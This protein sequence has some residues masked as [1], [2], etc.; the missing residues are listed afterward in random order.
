MASR[1]Q[2]DRI[3]KLIERIRNI[4]AEKLIRPNLGDLSLR[5]ELENRIPKMNNRLALIL[6]HLDQLTD[7]RVGYFA[8]GLTQLASLISTQATQDDSHFVSTR[9]SFVRQMDEI[10]SGLLGI[11]IHLIVPAIESKGLLGKSVFEEEK[12]TVLGE[13]RSEGKKALQEVRSEAA[14]ILMQAREAAK[15]IEGKARLTATGVSVE[16]AQRQF[17]EARQSYRNRAIVWGIAG[18]AF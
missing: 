3:R 15:N 12:A 14:G 17:G 9:E 7:E 4:Q 11:W 6:E 10:W 18:M 1:E 8:N 16:V 2:A 13:L 5:Q